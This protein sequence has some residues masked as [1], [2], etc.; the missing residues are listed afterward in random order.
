[1]RIPTT[2]TA[3][4]LTACVLLGA[5]RPTEENAPASAYEEFAQAFDQREFSKAWELLSTPTRDV[6]TQQAREIAAFRHLPPPGDGR[7]LAF[8][9]ILLGHHKV[10]SVEVANREERRAVLSVTDDAGSRQSVTVVREGPS[11]RVDLTGAL[12]QVRQ[13]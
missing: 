6:L 7:E 8:G 3:I 5:C 9:D 10:K 2:R 4:V 13:K 1:M 12:Q 11:W